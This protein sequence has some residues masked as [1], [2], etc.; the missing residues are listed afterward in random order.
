MIKNDKTAQN[1]IRGAIEIEKGILL[2]KYYRQA[3]L[4]K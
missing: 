4:D 3:L 1:E 2:T